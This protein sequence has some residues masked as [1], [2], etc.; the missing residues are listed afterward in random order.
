MEKLQKLSSSLALRMHNYVA[1]KEGKSSRFVATA[2]YVRPC[3]CESF[4]RVV[5]IFISF[6][7]FHYLYIITYKHLKKILDVLVQSNDFPRN[8]GAWNEL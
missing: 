8:S 1:N 5:H 7:G 4:Y 2:Q 3:L 6:V